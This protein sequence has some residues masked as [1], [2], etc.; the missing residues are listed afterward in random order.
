M[1]R[2]VTAVLG[3]KRRSTAVCSPC[4]MKGGN[5]GTGIRIE[6]A[7][8]QYICRDGIGRVGQV[9]KALSTHYEKQEEPNLNLLRVLQSWSTRE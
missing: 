5:E 8:E 2:M 4:A 3:A 7:S 1:L 9:N 6:N